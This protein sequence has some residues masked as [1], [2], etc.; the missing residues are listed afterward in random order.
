MVALTCSLNLAHGYAEISGRQNVCWAKSNNSQETNQLENKKSVVCMIS[1]LHEDI[2]PWS[3]GE[4][5]G[6]ILFPLGSWE[7]LDV[8]GSKVK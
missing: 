4:M 1:L 8:R 5:E 7:P 2:M 6:G 3:E